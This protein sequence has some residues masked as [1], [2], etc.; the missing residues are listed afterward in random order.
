M[1]HPVSRIVVL[2]SP[3]IT[4]ALWAGFLALDNGDVSAGGMIVFLLI[5]ALAVAAAETVRIQ[6]RKQMREDRAREWDNRA[7]DA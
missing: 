7:T 5:L 6:L 4:L 2:Y 3:A 1:Q